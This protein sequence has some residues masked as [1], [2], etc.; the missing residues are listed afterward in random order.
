MGDLKNY[1]NYVMGFLELDVTEA[2]KKI[3]DLR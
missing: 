2:L 1:R 3:H